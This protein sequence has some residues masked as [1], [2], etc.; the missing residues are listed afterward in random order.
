MYLMYDAGTVW[1]APPHSGSSESLGAR[2][3]P[4]MGLSVAATT[5]ADDSAQSAATATLESSMVACG[6]RSEEE[7]WGRG[8]GMLRRRYWRAV[9]RGWLSAVLS[10]DLTSPCF[11]MLFASARS[12]HVPA[13]LDTRSAPHRQTAEATARAEE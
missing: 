3:M 2:K 7:V 5:A 13:L 8:L 4:M 11:A 9:S 6:R 10:D 12:A 1:Q